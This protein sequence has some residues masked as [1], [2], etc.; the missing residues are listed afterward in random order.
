MRQGLLLVVRN[1]GHELV[2]QAEDEAAL[3]LWESAIKGAVRKR[4]ARGEVRQGLH[5]S[6]R[7]ENPRK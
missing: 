2:C 1:G 7:K 5:S 3:S 4:A 6:A